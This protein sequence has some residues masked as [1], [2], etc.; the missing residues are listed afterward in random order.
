MILWSMM[1]MKLKEA[2]VTM[3][4]KSEKNEVWK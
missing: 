2:M 1:D 4:T 3:P